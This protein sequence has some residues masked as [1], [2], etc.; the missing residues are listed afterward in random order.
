M[1]ISQTPAAIYR[2]QTAQYRVSA[3]PGC[4]RLGA[5]ALGELLVVEA[6]VLPPGRPVLGTPGLPGTCGHV[7]TR[8][9]V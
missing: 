2:G 7:L 9:F 5:G 4:E 1:E 6:A 8:W 3:C